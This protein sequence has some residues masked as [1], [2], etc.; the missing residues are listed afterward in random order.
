MLSEY[1][2]GDFCSRF[3][4]DEMKAVTIDIV[5]HWYALPLSYAVYTEGR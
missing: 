2:I 3:T 4:G 5:D 1:E